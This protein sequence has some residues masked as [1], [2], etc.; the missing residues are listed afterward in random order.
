MYT[1]PEQFAAANKNSVEALLTM[2]NTAFAS[3]STTKTPGRMK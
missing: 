3:A 2:A 1:T